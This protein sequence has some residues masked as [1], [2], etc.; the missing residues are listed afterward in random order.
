[1]NL[2]IKI[3]SIYNKQQSISY[4]FVILNNLLLN[5][6]NMLGIQNEQYGYYNISKAKKR[7]E[8]KCEFPLE[9]YCFQLSYKKVLL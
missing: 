4:N 8:L 1:M 5:A 3:N 9:L 6:E 2:E 7:E